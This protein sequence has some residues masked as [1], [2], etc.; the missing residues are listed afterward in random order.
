MRIKWANGPATEYF[1][2]WINV[3]NPFRTLLTLYIAHH[4]VISFKNFI[5]DYWEFTEFSHIL[6][7]IADR[8]FFKCY[9]KF[10]VRTLFC[11]DKLLVLTQPF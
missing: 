1:K 7:L 2:N 9:L 5:N 6:Q 11:S 3:I 4:I 8:Q 10:K